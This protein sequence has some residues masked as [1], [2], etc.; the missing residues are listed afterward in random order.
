M[1]IGVAAHV[2][3]VRDAM[4]EADRVA[5]GGRAME[6]LDASGGERPSDIG[7]QHFNLS[8]ST[9]TLHPM[10]T[11]SPPDRWSGVVGLCASVVQSECEFACPGF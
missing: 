10:P 5:P 7:M 3:L 8:S 2:W 11:R 9:T 6:V 4:G 1:A